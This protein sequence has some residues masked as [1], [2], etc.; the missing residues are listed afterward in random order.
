M[1]LSAL[2]LNAANGLLQ[3]EGLIVNPK[4]LSVMT[5]YATTPLIQ[6]LLTTM[7]VGNGNILSS[8]TISTLTTL[9]IGT[10]PALA[11]SAPYANIPASVRGFTGTLANT[12][13]VYLGSGNL[14]KFV[15]V[16]NQAQGYVSQTNYYIEASAA[17]Q[18]ALAPTFTNMNDLSSGGIT[19]ITTDPQALG[20]DLTNLGQLIN[21]ADLGNWG[22]PLALIEQLVNLTNLVPPPLQVAF[23]ALGID[24]TIAVNLSNSTSS[25]TDTI[26][27]RMWQ[28]LQNITGDSLAQILQLLE[29]TTVNIETAADLLN[30]MKILPNSY[31]TLRTPTVNGFVPIYLNTTGSVNPTLAT[32]LPGYALRATDAGYD[33]TEVD[34]MSFITTEPLAIANKSFAI[35]LLQLTDII[36]LTLPELAAAIS[37]TQVIDQPLINELTNPLPNSSFFSNYLAPG[38]TG[39]NLGTGNTLVI[40]DVIGIPAGY[41]ITG[42]FTNTIS[43]LNLIDTA[44]LANVYDVMANTVNGVYGNT[45]GNITIPGYGQFSNA[46]S[47]MSTALIPAAQANIIAIQTNYPGPVANLNQNWYTMGNQFLTEINMQQL[48]NIDYAQLSNVDNQSIMSFVENL[49]TY[50]PDV[51]PGGANGYLTS[52]ANTQNLTGQAIIATLQQGI[53]SSVYGT[54]GFSIPT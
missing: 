42:Q 54:L 13:Y 12:A 10:V 40:S 9:G 6:P 26:Q 11:D 39:P 45:Q 50:G 29:V 49:P 43:N 53:N 5:Q 47:A 18:V 34:R 32:E 15:Q 2:Q 28:A 31:L 35:S 51:V 21:L 14:N 4:M 8:N 41:Q 20:N 27:R 3:N 44:N 7:L 1:A 22:T 46:D 16:W 17:T 25:V 33:M 37:A 24:A 38:A 23:V 52:V 36:N 30:P 19:E 48:A